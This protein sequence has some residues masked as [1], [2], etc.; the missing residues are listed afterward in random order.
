MQLDEKLIRVEKRGRAG[1][2]SIHQNPTRGQM[3]TLMEQWRGIRGLV[4]SQ[5]LFVADAMEWTHMSLLNSLKENGLVPDTAR[6]SEYVNLLIAPENERMST[7]YGRPKEYEGW[8]LYT[9]NRFSF[10]RGYA[11]FQR[12]LPAPTLREMIEVINFSGTGS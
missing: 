6:L 2:W 10:A 4:D 9:S 12:I 5:N 7:Y 3:R 11:P 1:E 8:L